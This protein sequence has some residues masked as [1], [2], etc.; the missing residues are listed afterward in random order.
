M[1]S[2]TARMNMVKQQLRTGDVLNEPILELYETISR[3]QFVPNEFKHFAYSDMQIKLPHQQRMLTPLEEAQILQALELK[4]HEVLLEVGTGTGFLTALLS[5]LCHKVISVEYFAD[6]TASARHKLA[7]HNCSNVEL[8]TGDGSRGWLDK[9]PYDVIIF[10]GA[11]EFLTEM[12][13]LQV[14]PGGKLFAI[15]GIGPALQGQLHTLNH[16]GEWHKK[17]VFETS[18][19][20]LIDPLKP[21]DFVF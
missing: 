4:G 15:V 5:C 20:A 11:I 18:I 7:E 10:S 17:I 19:P 6:L 2:H 1:I 8:I 13:R 16:D 21:K 9:A 14:L 12:H 3:E